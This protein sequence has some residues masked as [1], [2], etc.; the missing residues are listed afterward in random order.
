M[1]EARARRCVPGVAAVIEETDG[2]LTYWALTHPVRPAGLSSPPRLRPA[3]R[4]PADRRRRHPATAR[5]ERPQRELR[6]RPALCR[7]RTCARTCA[8]GASHCWRILPRSRP[9]SR[10][11]STRWRALRRRAADRRV[12]SAA[13]PARR[14]A[15]QHGRVGR[16]PRPAARHSRVQPVRRSA[17]PDRRDA[18]HVRRAAGR[19]AGPRLPHL[20]VHHDAA[21]RARGRAR[22]T[23]SRSGCSIART[24]SAGRSRD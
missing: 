19:P 3:G 20:H 18:R 21:L 11:R 2:R 6:D 23:A 16:F 24:R 1:P 7:R 13:R 17:S 22:G 12:R 8:A 15:G 9:T 10:I 4:D 5:S 14:Q